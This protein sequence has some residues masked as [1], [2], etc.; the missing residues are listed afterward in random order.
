MKKM[1]TPLWKALLLEQRIPWRY[2]RKLNRFR[3]MLLKKLCCYKALCTKPV[4]TGVDKDSF[5]IHLLICH[6]D[7]G[8]LIYCLKSFLYFSEKAYHVVLHDDGSLTKKDIKR[9]KRHFVNIRILKKK[10]ADKLVYDKIK[11]YE[12]IKKYRYS[13]MCKN[14][15]YRTNFNPYVL[16]IK[17]LDFNLLSNAK[18]ILVLDTDILFFKKPIEILEWINDDKENRILSSVEQSPRNIFNSGILCINKDIFNLDHIEEWIK[19]NGIYDLTEQHVYESLMKKSGNYSELPTTYSHNKVLE[20]SISC[21][22]GIKFLFFDNLK[23][24]NNLLK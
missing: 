18:K 21:H 8:M 10:Q 2:K 3:L 14:W 19:N 1:P 13:Y 23:L 20:D 16:S 11:E 5:E 17:L 24:I 9:L 15:V 6:E 22:F 12:A 7:I 4:M